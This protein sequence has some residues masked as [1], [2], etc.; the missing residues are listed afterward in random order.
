MPSDGERVVEAQTPLSEL[1]EIRGT[2]PVL[3]P[4]QRECI[5]LIVRGVAG[6]AARPD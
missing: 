2:W 5:M 3:S 4:A 1:A 6:R